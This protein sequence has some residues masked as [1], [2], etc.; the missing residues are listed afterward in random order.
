MNINSLWKSKPKRNSRSSRSFSSC[1]GSTLGHEPECF[2]IQ[3][4]MEQ[5]DKLLLAEHARIQ[6]HID[7]LTE[8]RC[9]LKADCSCRHKFERQ[10]TKME[11]R[12]MK[13]RG[14]MQEVRKYLLD[15]D[16]YLNQ[17][18]QRQREMTHRL[19]ELWNLI[20]ECIEFRE[21]DL[22]GGPAPPA[23]SATSVKVVKTN[24][25]ITVQSSPA[26][27]SAVISTTQNA[28]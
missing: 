28:K 19:Q 24:P 12:V 20:T 5:F 6:D 8:L 9:E 3:R 1:H 14:E 21:V 25:V 15:S 16:C 26:N 13:L 7:E 11:K 2:R 22:D 10:L 27:S 17:N 18:E 4:R 23:T